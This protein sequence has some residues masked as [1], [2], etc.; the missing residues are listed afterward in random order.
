MKSRLRLVALVGLMGLVATGCF[1]MRGFSFSKP[2][3]DPGEVNVLTYKLQPFSPDGSRDYPFVVLGAPVNGDTGNPNVKVVAPKKFDTGSN[4]GGPRDLVLDNVL[5]DE[6]FY[7]NSLCLFGG[8]WDTDPTTYRIW[9]FRTTATVRDRGRVG[10]YALTKLG[11]K[12]L[13]STDSTGQFVK[14]AAG[15]WEDT[16]GDGTPEADNDSMGCNSAAET[17]I[18]IKQPAGTPAKSFKSRARNLYKRF[19]GR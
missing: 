7:D 16:D 3:V 1:T 10:K 12:P 4:F 6:L 9:V 15:A 8:D 14:L 2:I 18:L 19:S 5:R 11:I 17:S 13:A